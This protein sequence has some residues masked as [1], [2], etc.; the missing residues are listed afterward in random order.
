LLTGAVEA[1][2]LMTFLQSINQRQVGLRRYASHAEAH[3]EESPA[4][5]RFTGITLTLTIE[6]DTAAD[7]DSPGAVQAPI[8]PALDPQTISDGGIPPG[9]ERPV[10]TRE[11]SAAYRGFRDVLPVRAIQPHAG[12]S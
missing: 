12:G 9:Q 1:D 11:C 6:V 4:G 3:L 7:A 2:L 8:V 10:H 5:L